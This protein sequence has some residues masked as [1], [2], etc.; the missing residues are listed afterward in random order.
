VIGPVGR[1]SVFVSAYCAPR[2]C[3]RF[4]TNLT[5]SIWGDHRRLPVLPLDMD[6]PF[7]RDG[8][9]GSRRT[10]MSVEHRL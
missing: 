7:F 10:E 9:I 6:Q 1:L 5:T 3:G 8:K 4:G 2:L